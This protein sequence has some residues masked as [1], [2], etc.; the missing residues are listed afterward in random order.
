MHNVFLRYPGGKGKALTLSYDDGVVYDIKLM[1]ILNTYGLKCTFNI[2]SD[3]FSKVSLLTD[4]EN[5]DR[6]MTK[7]EAQKLYTDCGHEIAS[8]G[9]NHA[10]M[11]LMPRSRIAYETLEDRKRLE[12]MFGG[13]VRGM[14]YPYGAYNDDVKKVLRDCGIVYARTTKDTEHCSLPTDWLEWHPTCHHS[15]KKLEELCDGFLNRTITEAPKVF[16]MWGHSYEFNDGNCWDVIEKFAKKMGNRDEIWYAT[17][18]EIHD[19][20]EA[21]KQ[22]RFSSDGS[23][24]MNPTSTLIFLEVDKKIV[25]VLP[26]ET[27]RL[28]SHDF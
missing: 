6:R 11:H 21:W 8:H 12:D 27:K 22:L 16:Y 15:N 10:F 17:N 18:I 2:S 26:G 5:G 19:Y 23:L 13:I 20:V 7:E 24:V 28:Y 4:K 25:E 1:E 9:L 14:A 3:R